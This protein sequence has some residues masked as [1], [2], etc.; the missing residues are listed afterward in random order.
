MTAR[1]VVVTGLGPVTPIGIGGH[2]FW[3]AQLKGVSGIRPITRFDPTGLPVRIAGEVDLPA[4]LA[5]G[6]R[7]ERTT[8]R[9]TH[10]ALAAARLALDDAALDLADEDRDRVGVVLGTGAGGAAS[11]ER[12]ARLL[13]TSGPT[14][15]GA[16]S[17][18]MSMAN[19]SASHIALT[20]HITG[21]STSVVS[22][23]ASGAEALVTAHQMIVGGEADVVLAGGAEAPVTPLLVGGFARTG[24]L[25]TL[26][27]EPRHAS[28]PFSA[29][30]AGFV[31][32]EA[33][34][35]LVLE[36]QE[37]ARARGATVLATLSGYG[38][39]SDAHHVTSPH[40]EGAGAAR[41]VRAA[42]RSAGWSAADV[43]YINAHGTGTRYNDAAEAKALRSA[44]GSHAAHTPVSATKSM[45]G[46][47]LGAAGAVEAVVCVQALL[48]GHVPPTV[49]LNAVDPDCGLDVVGPQP[50]ALPLTTALSSSFAFGGHNVV[51]AFEAAR[52]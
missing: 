9:C 26:N 35:V 27:E 34:A 24:A 20:F 45:T 50:R 8:D 2:D 38:R 39:S 18:V 46:H 48:H 16:R 4:E 15:I 3:Q 51:L 28:R 12:N 10:L 52:P 42:L 44:L 41:A 40:P 21:P 11:W 31:L 5:P 1:T 7:E 17:V 36:S 13:E 32:A 43:D 30:R 25:C 29:D 33:A 14:R 22:A 37:H 19:G 23:C 47:S 49:N 6:R